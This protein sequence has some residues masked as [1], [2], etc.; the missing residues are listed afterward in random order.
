MG[1]PSKDTPRDT[2]QDEVSYPQC[3]PCSAG[4]ETP[5][6]TTAQT[7]PSQGPAVGKATFPLQLGGT[8]AGF[9]WAK[10]WVQRQLWSGSV[11]EVLA[12]HG[13]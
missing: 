12:S 8:S 7:G 5:A 1:I 3:L 13:L 10:L 9:T 2:E 6:L 11:G 4:S